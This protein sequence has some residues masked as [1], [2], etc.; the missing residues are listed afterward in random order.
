[1]DLLPNT[2]SLRSHH[3]WLR[4]PVPGLAVDGLDQSDPVRH[5]VGLFLHH[6]GDVRTGPAA[7]KGRLAAQG[8]GR[9]PVVV[10]LRPQSGLWR[11]AQDESQQAVCHD[12]ARADLVCTT[13]IVIFRS[14]SP[15]VTLIDTG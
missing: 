6:E 15:F 12:G 13:R 5:R 4:D 14:L 9:S 1:M 11:S 3:R 2:C 10:S 7:Q 8:N